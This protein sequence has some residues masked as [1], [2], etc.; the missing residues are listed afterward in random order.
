M[1]KLKKLQEQYLKG[2]IT[3]AQYNAEVKKLL[4]EEI[5][6]QDQ[7]DD[8]L[9]YDPEHERPQFSQAD[10][11]AMITSK[12]VKMVRKALKDAG[13]TIE[14][15][16]KTLLSAVAEK[17]KATP[18]KKDA[19]GSGA[20]DGANAEELT[21]L[22]KQAD[23]VPQLAEK[24][25]DLTV[26]NAVLREAGKYNPVNPVQVVR[27]LRS[28]YMDL[29]DIDEETGE[30]DIKSVGRALKKVSEAEPNLFK[31]D[32]D[33][34]NKGADFKGKGPGGGSGAADTKHAAKKSEALKMLGLDKENK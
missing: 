8:A 28:D 15:D 29:I 25:K 22:R 19:A 21:N 7:Y 5:L 3:K 32:D 27:A 31:T 17:L 10:V 2:E 16:N 12:A 11:D 1:T 24:V 4:D 34:N 6:D 14:A 20:G 23:R 33:P 26:E 9:E 18:E 13:V 30:V